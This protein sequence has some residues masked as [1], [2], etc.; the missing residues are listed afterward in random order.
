MKKLVIGTLVMSAAV[1]T[2]VHAKFTIE[3]KTWTD[4]SGKEVPR[5]VEWRWDGVE[6]RTTTVN[7]DQEVDT[8]DV[9]PVHFVR[10]N[11]GHDD[12]SAYYAFVLSVGKDGDRLSRTIHVFTYAERTFAFDHL[13]TITKEGA[14]IRPIESGHSDC[15]WTKY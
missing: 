5:P 11:L 13:A 7:A 14:L 15:T 3:C 2:P 6:L 8:H 12:H 4:A 10:R 1:V 9:T